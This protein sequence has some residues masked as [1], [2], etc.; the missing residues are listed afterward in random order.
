VD[1][2][3]LSS[4]NET[5]Y[6]VELVP[7]KPPV[8]K[9]IEPVGESETIT[10]RARPMIIFEASDD[11]GVTKLALLYQVTPPPIAG[12]EEGVAQQ[13]QRI[14]VPVKAPKDGTHYEVALDPTTQSPPWQEGWTVHY[15]IEATDNNT[16]TGPG[17]T[18][19]EVKQF[20]IISPEEKEAEV[21]ER[22]RNNAAEINT[23]SDTQEK[24]S[25][26]VQNTIPKK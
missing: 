15:W 1:E 26:D 22:I 18:K 21:L 10:L 5:V 8:V 20:V 11:Y 9:M 25:H 19:S 2:A 12:Q 7:D 13:V 4:A 3:G 6:P 24:E 14:A 23:L 17:V 16:A